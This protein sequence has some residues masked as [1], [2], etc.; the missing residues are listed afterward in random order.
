MR[1][2]GRNDHDLCAV[3]PPPLPPSLQPRSQRRASQSVG[4]GADVDPSSLSRHT[5]DPVPSHALTRPTTLA[6]AAYTSTRARALALGQRRDGRW[7]V[8]R[9]RYG[10][11]PHRFRWTRAVCSS[12]CARPCFRFVLGCPILCIRVPAACPPARPSARPSSRHPRSRCRRLVPTGFSMQGDA[13]W[14][15]SAAVQVPSVQATPSV[16]HARIPHPRMRR[17]V[18]ACST[19]VRRLSELAAGRRVQPTEPML[20]SIGPSAHRPMVVCCASAADGS[21]GAARRCAA[22]ALCP[23]RL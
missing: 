5:C 8:C 7:G 21:A 10:M 4:P 11:R 15:P 18:D 3:V 14:V 17:A 9:Q 16:G 12:L 6:G 23:R 20:R 1:A 2:H 19:A 22:A 13:L